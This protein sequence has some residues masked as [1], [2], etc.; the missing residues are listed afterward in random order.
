M[1]KSIITAAIL[2][3]TAGFASSASAIT[4]SYSQNSGFAFNTVT[5]TTGAIGVNTQVLPFV[6]PDP[7]YQ[8]LWWG[9]DPHVRGTASATT[10]INVTMTDNAVVSATAAG[11]TTDG[12]PD[13]ALKVIS[14]SGNVTSGA[15]WVPISHTFHSNQ[16]IAASENVLTSGIIRSVLN[17]GGINEPANDIPFSFIETPNNDSNYFCPKTSIS[18]DIFQF[19]T[20]GFGTIPLDIDG[21][22]Y[23]LTFALMGTSPGAYIIN[24][25][26]TWGN[27]A[28]QA[29]NF[30]VL[31]RE[32]SVNWLTVGMRLDEH[33]IPEP[34]SLALMSLGLLGLGASLRRRKNNA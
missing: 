8:S 15:G 2:A 14:L 7:R 10:P 27:S 4:L 11:W 9:Q 3:A 1:K 25:G 21:T 16:A 13:S 23:D 20:A 26:D 28:C 22:L 12:S 29:G 24:P 6:A 31:T 30:C 5:P 17:V 33:N 19:S 32:D 18:C 34:A